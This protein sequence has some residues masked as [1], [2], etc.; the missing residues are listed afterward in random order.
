M[1]IMLKLRKLDISC[2]AV[3]LNKLILEKEVSNMIDWSNYSQNTYGWT[4]S[5]SI[6]GWINMLEGFWFKK[7]NEDSVILDFVTS[8]KFM[9]VDTHFKKIWAVNYF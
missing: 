2:I 5:Q 4:Y 8:Y 3:V 6:F 9:I 1:I 7:R